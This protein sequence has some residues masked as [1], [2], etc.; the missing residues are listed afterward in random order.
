MSINSAE[1]H[2]A[3]TTDRTLRIAAEAGVQDV[4]DMRARIPPNRLVLDG[5]CRIKAAATRSPSRLLSS[6]SSIRVPQFDG[7]GQLRLWLSDAIVIEQN[8]TFLDVAVFD[9]GE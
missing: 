6:Q 2:A 8:E 7:H 9:R 4:T 1:R 5:L 3:L